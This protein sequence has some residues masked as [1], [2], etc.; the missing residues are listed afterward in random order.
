MPVALVNE[1]LARRYWPGR[2]PI[3]GRMRIGMRPDRPWVTVVGIVRDVR[4]NGVTGVVK[5][6]FYVPHAQWHLSI[7]PMRS[8]FLVVRGTGDVRRLAPSIRA[9]VRARDP[10]IPLADI[11]T[12]DDV[13]DTALSRPRF[14]GAL[15]TVFS[16]LAVLLAAV[17][18]YG[19]LSY[20][21]TQQT[22]EIGIR[23]AV[24]ATPADVA[25]TVL[26]RGFLLS[27]I[28]LAIGGAIALALG[29]AV[30]VLLY[31]VRPSDP[32]SLVAGVFVLLAVALIASYIPARRATKVDPMVAL[33]AE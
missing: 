5:E 31:N 9:E 8:M 26:G 14:T 25:R 10:R 1:E 24:G 15:F 30:N 18:I 2:D 32:V 16:V 3:G 21:V 4:H 29:G 33:R 27:V 12:M 11:R 20:V 23:L 28:G 13:V 7:G 6:K 19:V 17:G 22:R